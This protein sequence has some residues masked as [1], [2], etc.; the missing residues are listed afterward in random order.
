LRLVFFP[1]SSVLF[2]PIW[3]DDFAYFIEKTA[4]EQLLK[5]KKKVPLNFSQE[6]TNLSNSVPMFPTADV[7]PL[8]KKNNSFFYWF[9]GQGLI[10]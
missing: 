5:K 9:L 6:P 1:Q 10:M 2:P 7:T 4:I 8:K 3:A